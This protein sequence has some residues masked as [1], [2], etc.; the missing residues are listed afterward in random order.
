MAVILITGGARSGKSKRAEM[1]TRAFPGQPVYVATAEALMPKWR[2]A[3]PDIARAAGPTGSNAKCRSIS[4]PRC[5]Q[6]MAAARG[7]SIA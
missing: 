3:S 6:P 1:R 5:S 7:S 2:R 4:C